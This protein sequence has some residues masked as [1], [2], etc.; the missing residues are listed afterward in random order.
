MFGGFSPDAL[1]GRII[2]CDSTIIITADEGRR[3][4]KRVPLKANVD[5]ALDQSY[6]V[7]TV[8]VVKATGGA[9]AM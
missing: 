8:I 4:G 1:A 9:I 5:A 3:G 6:S 7:K 2:D